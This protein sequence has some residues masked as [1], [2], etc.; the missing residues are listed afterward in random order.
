MNKLNFFW[1]EAKKYNLQKMNWEQKQF[2]GFKVLIIILSKIFFFNFYL[3]KKKKLYYFKIYT[4]LEINF[5]NL[6]LK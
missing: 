6:Y 3:F 4:Y 2:K 1:K 5:E